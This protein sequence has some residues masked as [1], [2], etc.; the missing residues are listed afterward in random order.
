MKAREDP[1]PGLSL[2]VEDSSNSSVVL[3]D[4]FIQVDPSHLSLREMNVSNVGDST[5]F[6]SIHPDFLPDHQTVRV[7]I[8]DNISS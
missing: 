6:G 7:L 8:E 5:L 4:R 2:K 3:A 1:V